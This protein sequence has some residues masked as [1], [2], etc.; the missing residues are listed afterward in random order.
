MAVFLLSLFSGVALVLAALGIYGVMAYVVTGRTHEIGVRMALGAM[1]R[2]VNRLILGQGA[3][4][5]LDW[6]SRRRDLVAG[7]DPP[8]SLYAVWRQCHGSGVFAGVVAMLGGI[9]ILACYIPA[10]ARWASIQSRAALRVKA[11]PSASSGFWRDAD[12]AF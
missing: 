7:P 10:R 3:R 5:T 8:Y 1:P 12:G 2:D 6:G 11:L 4:V 9:A